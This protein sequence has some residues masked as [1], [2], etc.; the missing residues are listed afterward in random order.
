MET[1]VVAV[2][3][4]V[5]SDA[6]MAAAT[7]ASSTPEPATRATEAK[8]SDP[9]AFE[10]LLGELKYG[11]EFLVSK[12]SL[13]EP[14][15]GRMDLAIARLERSIHRDGMAGQGG[16]LSAKQGFSATKG[17]GC[18]TVANEMGDQVTSGIAGQ[19]RGLAEEQHLF[20]D[21]LHE[22][23]NFTALS[24]SR[25]LAKMDQSAAMSQPAV[26]I[27]TS[28]P[29]I[30]GG[31][32]KQ[33]IRPGMDRPG[34]P[35]MVP[36]VEVKNNHKSPTTASALYHADGTGERRKDR[37]GSIFAD[38]FGGTRANIAKHLRQKLGSDSNAR[39]TF[40]FYTQVT[41]AIR[42]GAETPLAHGKEYVDTLEDDMRRLAMVKADVADS[43]AAAR[44]LH[45]R[46]FMDDAF[47]PL[48]ASTSSLSKAVGKLERDMPPLLSQFSQ[49]VGSLRTVFGELREALNFTSLGDAY[50][51]TLSEEE[52]FWK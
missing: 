37:L 6:V 12:V 9:L 35:L 5:V 44:S 48:R 31:G 46:V 30:V 40:F 22:L 14:R 16:H 18:V 33:A 17:H 25:I 21:M 11:M 24:S 52:D 49:T 50:Y 20:Q 15:L 4:S 28:R 51:V 41:E 1:L 47:E 29:V 43:S 36:V 19:L 7:T 26:N 34:R 23:R 2:V 32:T 39:A 38:L 3:L 27:Q 8:T 10:R 45:F 42:R 13:M